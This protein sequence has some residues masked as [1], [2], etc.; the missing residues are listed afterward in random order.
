MNDHV[1]ASRDHVNDHVNA[2]RDHV[3]DHVK[4]S[5]DAKCRLR[6]FHRYRFMCRLGRA[7]P[8]MEDLL[9]GKLIKATMCTYCLKSIF[10]RM[11]T[12]R[13][14]PRARRCTLQA[15]ETVRLVG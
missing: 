11:R 4:G 12:T 10:L 2:S 6:L 1:N 7:D 15:S 5:C 9:T 13:S 3:K 8:L 14:M